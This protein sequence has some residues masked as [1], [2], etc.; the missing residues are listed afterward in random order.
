[1]KKLLVTAI[2]TLTFATTAATGAEDLYVQSKSA[3]IMSSPSFDSD[4]AGTVRRGD[5]L[6]ISQKADGW[7]KV[8]HGSITGW[9]NSLNVA[10]QMPKEKVSPVRNSD[11]TIN[12]EARRRS[13][14]MTSAA[15]ARG[16]SEKERK[17]VSRNDDPDY[18]ALKKLEDET[19]SI[20]DKK[21]EKFSKTGK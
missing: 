18:P 3:K 15:S 21:V 6:K 4:V 16:L 12:K 9:V 14:A 8:K 20:P 11:K 17:R 2:F 5:S 13:S 7:Y 19:K 1:M 10:R